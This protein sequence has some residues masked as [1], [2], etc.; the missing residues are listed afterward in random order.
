MIDSGSR[1][2]KCARLLALSNVRRIFAFATHGLFTKNALRLI[3]DSPIL[4]VVVTNTIAIKDV[5]TRF[6]TF[7][8][9]SFCFSFCSVQY[10]PKIRHLSVAGLLAECIRRIHGNESVSALYK[11]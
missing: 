3:E 11:I 8:L 2:T 6:R 5:S 1:V 10:H 7:D 9:L 4:E